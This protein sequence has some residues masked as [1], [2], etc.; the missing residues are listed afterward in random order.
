ML[1][2]SWISNERCAASKSLPDII[3]FSI[4][5]AC[6]NNFFSKAK[7]LILRASAAWALKSLVKLPAVCSINFWLYK[8]SPNSLACIPKALAIASC[9]ITFIAA[10]LSAVIFWFAISCVN[11]AMSWF[12]AN[13]L[14]FSKLIFLP[15]N[16][17]AS[18][19]ADID[20]SKS[21]N[22]LPILL[23]WSKDKPNLLACK[24]DFTNDSKLPLKLSRI[25]LLVLFI[26]SNVFLPLATIPF[27]LENAAIWL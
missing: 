11:P 6:N 19:S 13:N 4:P 24:V 15:V 21:N 18:S 23:T 7:L 2:L 10:K 22:E 26:S 20:D 8:A 5:S 3:P 14:A 12:K 16:N 9:W 1:N 17:S 27:C 25:N